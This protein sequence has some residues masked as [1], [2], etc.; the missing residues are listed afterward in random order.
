MTYDALN[1]P[2]TKAIP[3]LSTIY[4]SYD[5]LTHPTAITYCS[6]TGQGNY[7][8]YDA[9]GRMTSETSYGLKMSYQYS[10]AGLMTQLSWWDGQFI[11]YDYDV[12]GEMTA[13]RENNAA[14]GSGIG[15]LAR[16]SYDDLG[17]RTAVAWGNG[18]STGYQY[19]AISRLTQL[20]HSM[21]GSS[22]DQ[23]QTYTLAYSPA[24]QI[25]SLGMTNPA[26]VW[27][28][29][30]SSTAYTV[31]GLNELTASGGVTI[32]NDARGNLS[33]DGVTSYVY[34]PRNLLTST[35]TSAGPGA[36]LTYDPESQ[37]STLTRGGATTQFV[38][39][40]PDIVA[41]V[42]PLAGNAIMRR[43]VPGPA[44]DETIVWY[45]GAGTSDRRWLLP[46]HQGSVVAV[47]NASG[48]AMQVNTYDEYGVPGAS[49]LGRF[50]YT[51]QAWLAEVGLFD[52]KARL[53][54]PTLGRFMQTDPIGYKDGM[55][56]Y[57]YV[58]DDPVD[59]ADPAG[60]D[61]IPCAV[62]QMPG[63]GPSQ[64]AADNFNT[65]VE[66]VSSFVNELGGALLAY[67]ST[68]AEGKVLEG[69]GGAIK[70]AEI[71]AG[72]ASAGSRA[73]DL[74]GQ[75]STRTQASVTIAVTETKQGTR[76]VTSS[77]GTLRP[78]VK[79]ALKPGEIAGQ[80]AK[81]VHAEV[82]GVNAAK[83]AGLTPTGVA[84]SRPICTNCAA[85]LKDAGVKPLSPLKKPNG[86]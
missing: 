29:S 27:T 45:E 48:A 38:Y 59:N 66:A 69:L 49:N 47:T 52:Y 65:Q 78:G 81:G 54:S 31:N 51:G 6:A 37:L 9:L 15:V 25:K 4:T 68:G 7:K 50:Q 75:M 12:S 8:A 56:W 13:I 86:Q 2:I 30:A 76:I 46:D 85:A 83:G 23:S 40:G 72:A 80:G 32:N 62:G 61:C 70:G 11:D 55:N 67:P 79:A 43:Y 60:T 36:S 39:S 44:E 57:A 5:L 73:T 35:S 34:D 41:E 10:L 71:D 63:Q 24:S 28:P 82:N 84:A 20:S 42:N 16:Y 22:N 21:A 14:L 26:Y 3:G 18:N 64:Q 74:A 19:D 17:R 53:Y 1:R 77:E 58:G 33:S